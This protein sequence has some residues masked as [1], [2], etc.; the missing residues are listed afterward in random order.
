LLERR[1]STTATKLFINPMP[2]MV[3]EPKFRTF[4][5]TRPALKWDEYSVQLPKQK[6]I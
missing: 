3:N 4:T 6:N 5:A 2:F 1:F